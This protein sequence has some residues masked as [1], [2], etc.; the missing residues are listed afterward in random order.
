[1]FGRALAVS[2]LVGA[3]ADLGLLNDSGNTAADVA[4]D[5]IKAL[6]AAFTDAF[7]A[8]PAPGQFRPDEDEE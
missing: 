1:M 4:T 3:G 6:L 5:E 8:S 2:A 7:A